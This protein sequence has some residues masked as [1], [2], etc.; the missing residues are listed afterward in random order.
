MTATTPVYAFP[1]PQGT[2]RVM[3]GDNAI[4]ALALA[5]ENLLKPGSMTAL[6]PTV[7]QLGSSVW[8]LGDYGGGA[9]ASGDTAGWFRERSGIISGWQLAVLNGNG[10]TF[11][12]A[13]AVLF[14]AKLPIVPGATVPNRYVVGDYIYTHY[15]GTTQATGLLRYDTS[16]AGTDASNAW[17]RS[18]GVLNSSNQYSLAIRWYYPIALP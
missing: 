7:K 17:A 15:D 16:T 12:P 8:T 3:D 4:Q 9:G 1:Y 18:S 14:N 2:D 13:T 6:D 10:P 11:P 5:V